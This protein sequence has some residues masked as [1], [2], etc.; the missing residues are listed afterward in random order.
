VRFSVFDPFAQKDDVLWMESTTLGKV[1]MKK[2]SKTNGWLESKYGKKIET[3]ECSMTMANDFRNTEGEF[4]DKGLNF[5]Y[6]YCRQR[7]P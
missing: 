6:Q 1:A 5:N 2:S 3:W 7:G 4:Q